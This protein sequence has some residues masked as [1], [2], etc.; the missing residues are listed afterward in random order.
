MSEEKKKEEEKKKQIAMAQNSTEL[1]KLS[2]G[3]ANAL[4]MQ[5]QLNRSMAQIALKTLQPVLDFSYLSATL[6]SMTPALD[7]MRQNQAI[8]QAIKPPALEGILESQRQISQ[9]TASLVAI[10]KLI[11]V[12]KISMPELKTTSNKIPTQHNTLVRSLLSQIEYLETELAKEKG[13][14]KELLALLDEKRKELKKQ[15]VA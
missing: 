10:N 9:I 15:Y 14:N 7:M 1:T 11:Q 3:F 13:K 4:K 5:E 6:H 2:I 8:L 12:P